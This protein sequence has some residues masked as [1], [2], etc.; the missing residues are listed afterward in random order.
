MTGEQAAQ[1]LK[2]YLWE[3][4]RKEILEYQN[5]YWFNIAER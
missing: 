4:E 5:V 1:V 3:Y 2:D